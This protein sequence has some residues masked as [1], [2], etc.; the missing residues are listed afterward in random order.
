MGPLF[1][2][3]KPWTFHNRIA[4]SLY[5]HCNYIPVYVAI[6]NMHVV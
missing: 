1:A 5:A 2:C 4:I 3:I 6:A